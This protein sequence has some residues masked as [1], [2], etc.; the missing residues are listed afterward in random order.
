MFLQ[1]VD[2]Q[3]HTNKHTNTL[4]NYH[5]Q[6]YDISFLVTN[7]HL[8]NLYRQKVIDFVIYFLEEVNREISEMSEL[9]VSYM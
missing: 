1:N 8:D 5:Y 3:L 9:F 4:S 2:K 6:G 7:F